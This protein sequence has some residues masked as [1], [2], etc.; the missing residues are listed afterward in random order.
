MSPRIHRRI[1]RAGATL[2]LV[3]ALGACDSILGTSDGLPA[4]A[5]I[6]VTG[7]SAVPM[8]VVMSNNFFASWD[9]QNGRYNIDLIAADTLTFDVPLSHTF[10][11]NRAPGFY[12]VL[13]NTDTETTAN[14]RLRVRMDR[15]TVFDQQAAMRDARLEYVYFHN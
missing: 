10:P 6:D 7:S 9:A 15:T 1:A 2:A 12:V 8:R 13:A 3:L 14:V 11:L 4:N 5:F